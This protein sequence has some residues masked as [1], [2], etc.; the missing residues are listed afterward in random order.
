[1]WLTF[2]KCVENVIL[3]Q[4]SGGTSAK[5]QYC[6]KGTQFLIQ[7]IAV[8]FSYPILFNFIAKHSCSVIF[9]WVMALAFPMLPYKS[10]MNNLWIKFVKIQM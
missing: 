6:H 1:M 3:L 4:I 5:P 9:M 2:R 10:N 8:H 7:P